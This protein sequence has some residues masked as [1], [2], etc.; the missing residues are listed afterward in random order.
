MNEIKGKED[1]EK[2]MAYEKE[3]CIS[4]YMKTKKAASSEIKNM[5]IKYKNLLSEVER[6]LEKDWDFKNKEKEE[7]LESA[8]I[9]IGERTFW[10][11]Q[12]EGLAIFISPDI[13]SYYQ[14]S[15]AVKDQVFVSKHFNIKQIIP[16][17]QSERSYNVLALSRNNNRF[18]QCN[19]ESIKKIEVDEVPKNIDEALKYDDREKTLQYRSHSDSGRTKAIFHGQGSTREDNKEYL[20]RYLRQVEQGLNDQLNKDNKALVLMCVKELFPL[21]KQ[22]NSYSKMMDGFIRGN[23]DKLQAKE[24]HQQSWQLM[25]SHFNEKKQKVISRYNE[26]KATE[27]TSE[28]L[29]AII[30]AAVF[31]KVDKLLL[32]KDALQ[33]GKYN[34]EKNEV[35]LANEADSENYDL[36]NFAALKTLNAGG[37]VHILEA[38][39]MPEEKEILAIYRF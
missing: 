4:L 2:L 39:M 6:K 19:K 25:K 13:S 17:L 34:L 32:K 12:N 1:I 31:S 3:P 22:V 18:F 29:S 16:E 33:W 14:L 5:S 21:Y 35:L 11:H 7:F 26:L 15:I 20:L 23:P 8:K 36:Y 9:L 30:K 37:N 38:E 10:Q 24:I 27:K 28:D